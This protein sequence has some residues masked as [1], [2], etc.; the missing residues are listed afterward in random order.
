MLNYV[1]KYFT[2][3][4]IILYFIALALVSFLFMNR[5]IDLQFM[6]F[7][8]LAVIGFFYFSNTLSLKWQQMSEKKYIKKIFWTAF[9]LRLVWVTFSYF[10]YRAM[11]GFVFEFGMADSGHY[12]SMAWDL[13]MIDGGFFVVWEALM[14]R[15]GDFSDAG[16]VLFLS[17]FYRLFWWSDAYISETGAYPIFLMRVTHAL[18]SAFMCI[19]IYKLT[20]RN[21]GES[22]GR[23]A[24]V[25]AML[26]PHFI[27]Y[28]GLHLKETYMIF[29]AVAFV[30]RADHLLRSK[31]YNFVNIAI[32]VLLVGSLFTFRTVLG[33]AGLFAFFTAIVFAPSKIVNWK[34]RVLIGVWIIAVVAYFAGGRI[35]MEIEEHWEGRHDNMELGFEHRVQQEGANQFARYATG[36]VFAPVI[37]VIPFPAMTY[38]DGQQNQM[39]INGNAF[40][41][42][43]TAFFTMLGIFLLIYRKRWREHTLILAFLISYLGVISTTVFVTSDRFHLPSVP[44]A[45]IMAAYGISQMTNQWK[46]YFNW[47]TI[48]IFI[49]IVGWSWQRLAGRGV[50]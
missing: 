50:M 48:F 41:K 34:K 19:L 11:T 10:Y 43:I 4:A 40:V 3:R 42:N 38:V 49:A 39:M 16:Y 31:N 44:F 8:V 20:K 22:T 45:L 32:P 47:W 1:P 5:M 36:A 6:F 9:V 25:L 35:A 18:A 37:F 30:E 29:L 12:H 26:M 27:Y 13:M 14:E 23:I 17:Y 24:G 46:K 15:W 33:L 21:F 2:N 7:G 28:C